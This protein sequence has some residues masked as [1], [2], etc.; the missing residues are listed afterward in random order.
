MPAGRP[1]IGDRRDRGDLRQGGADDVVR[2]VE[3]RKVELLLQARRQ[4]LTA[5]ERIGTTLIDDVCLPRTK[6]AEMVERI[7]QIS[8]ATGLTIATVAHAGDGNFHPNVVFD[9]SVPG[10]QD[11]AVM[12]FDEIMQIALELG[13]TITGEHG[14]GV[15]KKRLL[16][17]ELGSLNLDVHRRVKAAFDPDGILNPG[18]VFDL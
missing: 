3:P 13:G 8:E 16:A 2:A 4:A 7:E 6:L 15:L 5:L 9:P 11:R 10:E 18:K 12:V 17:D 1:P 14:V